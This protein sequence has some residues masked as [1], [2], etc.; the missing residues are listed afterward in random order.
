MLPQ[1][2]F[3]D[4]VKNPTIDYYLVTWKIYFTLIICV[5]WMTHLSAHWSL[6]SSA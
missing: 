6:I 5:V 2:I 4:A 3:N 1:R